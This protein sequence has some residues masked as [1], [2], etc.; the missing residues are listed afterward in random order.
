MWVSAPS[1]KSS[2]F[3]ILDVHDKASELISC[4]ELFTNQIF[5]NQ[6]SDMGPLGPVQ[7]AIRSRADAAKDQ[8]FYRDGSEIIALLHPCEVV[9]G[10]SLSLVKRC[11]SNSIMTIVTTSLSRERNRSSAVV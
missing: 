1:L 11:L 9:K 5:L 8:T 4:F 2:H 6:P 3:Y 10:H 7:Q